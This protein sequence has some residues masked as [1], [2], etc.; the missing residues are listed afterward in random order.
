MGGLLQDNGSEEERSGAV[1]ADQ[2]TGRP[3]ELS[4]N[5][6]LERHQSIASFVRRFASGNASTSEPCGVGPPWLIDNRLPM[7][8]RP[9]AYD[10][11]GMTPLLVV[12]VTLVR[13]AR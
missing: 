7:T 9:T 11:Q 13:T 12:M 1:A 8:I 10:S 2:V 6:F 4:Q 3:Q 5:L